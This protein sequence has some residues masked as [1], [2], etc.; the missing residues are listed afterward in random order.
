MIGNE[1]PLLSKCNLFQE[2]RIV[3]SHDSGDFLLRT[4]RL[5]IL[6]SRLEPQLYMLIGNKIQHHISKN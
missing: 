1:V 3:G 4:K 5:H 6:E 2:D